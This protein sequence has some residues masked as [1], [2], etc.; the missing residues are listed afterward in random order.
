MTL[1]YKKICEINWTGIR[2]G[3][4]EYYDLRIALVVWENGFYYKLLLDHP[5]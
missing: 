1:H 5:G 2:C 4:L 3:T